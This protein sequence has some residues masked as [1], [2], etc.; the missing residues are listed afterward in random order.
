LDSCAK[1]CEKGIWKYGK[2]RAFYLNQARAYAQLD[3]RVAAQESA[4]RGLAQFPGD[5]ALLRFL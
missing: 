3:D 2:E 1:L 5:S 4:R